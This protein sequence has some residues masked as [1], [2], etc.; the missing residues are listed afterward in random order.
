MRVWN[1][2]LVAVLAGTATPVLLHHQVHG[3][4]SPVQ[5]VLAFFLWLNVIIALWELC[6]FFRID[7]IEA[8][9]TRMRHTYRGREIT[10]IK[11]FMR[12]EVP[13]GRLLSPTL[14][15]G[16][17]SSYSLFDESYASKKSFGFFVDVGN[18]F[19]TLVPSLLFLH[20]MTFQQLPARALGIVG[21][22]LFYQMWYG[23]VVY[24]G[25]Y[26]LNRRHVGR[27]LWHVA[28][29]V[30]V[31]NGLWLTFPLLGIYASISMIYS[32]SYAMFM[33]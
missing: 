2:I 28:V 11:D 13:A 12:S 16:I 33:S 29:I 14:W 3:V 4:L 17:W 21:L 10:R 5:L 25:S 15:A 23:T 27:P 31:L 20:Q 22:L 9:H 7:R 26:F 6:L 24:L 18:G 1:V 8:E 30:V 32:S 19:T